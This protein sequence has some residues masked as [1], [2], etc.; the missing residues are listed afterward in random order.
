MSKQEQTQ[1]GAV[2][3]PVRNGNHKPINQHLKYRK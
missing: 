3:K 1:K 2:C